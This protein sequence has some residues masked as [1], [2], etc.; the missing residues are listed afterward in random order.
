MTFH[1]VPGNGKT[2]SQAWRRGRGLGIASKAFEHM[3]Q[4]LRAD[5]DAIVFD[6]DCRRARG[7]GGVDSD[8]AARLREFR[9][10]R[11]QVREYLLETNRVSGHP[12]WCVLDRGGQLNVTVI[13]GRTHFFDC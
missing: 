6:Y 2:E 7:A 10:V 4:E 8:V 5:A 13:E 3:R 11:Q 1:E 9:R 12:E